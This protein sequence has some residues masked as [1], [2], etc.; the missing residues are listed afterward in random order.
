VHASPAAYRAVSALLARLRFLVPRRLGAWGRTR[1]TP[2]VAP[3][4][5]HRLARE[6]GFEGQ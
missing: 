5:L 4:G 2:A 1:S 6:E 3:K